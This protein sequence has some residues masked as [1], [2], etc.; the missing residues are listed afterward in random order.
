MTTL[1]FHDD[2]PAGNRADA[3]DAQEV[4]DADAINPTP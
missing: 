1:P 2:G 3:H 4:R